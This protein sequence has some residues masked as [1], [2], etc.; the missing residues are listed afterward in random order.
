M[1]K[2]RRGLV[3]LLV[4]VSL[5]LAAGL[6]GP[7]TTLTGTRAICS[8]QH[9]ATL[10]HRLAVDSAVAALPALL[11]HDPQ[12]RRNLDRDNMARFEFS[13]GD[14]QVVVLV[15]DDSAKLPVELLT[16][17]SR[18]QAY[19]AL[20]HFRPLVICSANILPEPNT[21]VQ[22][23]GC[24]DDLFEEPTDA[25]LYGT[26]DSGTAWSHYI[27]PI[28]QTVNLRRAPPAVLTAVC[29]DLP[30]QVGRLLAQA[31]T[32]HVG[33]NVRTLLADMDITTPQRRELSARL[34]ANT[35]RYSLLVSSTLEGYTRQRYLICDT[36]DPAT[37]LLDWEVS[38]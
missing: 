5:T 31:R 12:L 30:P 4:L 11:A 16:R 1:N 37:V 21:S 18:D 6:I 35:Q 14:M 29:S 32:E 8:V 13:L 36:G 20:N 17:V 2:R 26:P 33:R 34:T 27:T 10:Q 28:G 22:V 15:Q 23:T 19:Q 25:A 9:A 3:L 38:P 24:L 7:L